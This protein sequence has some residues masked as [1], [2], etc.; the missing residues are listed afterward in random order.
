[1]IL[2]N[3]GYNWVYDRIFM[4]YKLDIMFSSLIWDIPL[5]KSLW[6]SFYIHDNKKFPCGICLNPVAKNHTVVKNNKAVKCDNCYLWIHI[7][8]NKL[9]IQIYSLLINDNT[10]W[11][12]LTCSKKLYHFSALNDNDFHSNIQGKTI[13]FKAFTRKRS[14]VEN[15]LIDKLND[16]VSESD[17]ENF[18]QYFQVDDF[19]EAFTQVPLRVPIFFHMNISSLTYNFDQLHTLLIEINISFDVIRITETRFKK[20]TLKTTNIDINGYN[21]EHTPTETFCGGTLLYVKIKPNYISRK[22]LKTYKKNELMSTFIEIL[23]SS[24]K[25]II[26]KCICRHPCM[27]PWEFNDIYLKDPREN[28]SHESKTI[29]EMGDFNIDL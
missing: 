23:T 26:V 28:L 21:L 4:P 25:S 14:S 8:C 3:T 20:K 24:G 15:D 19:K 22:D 9:T 5:Y 27:H 29:V 16:V 1:M 17:L 10:A 13:K 18:S 6:T 2:L 7:K 12:C 11:Y